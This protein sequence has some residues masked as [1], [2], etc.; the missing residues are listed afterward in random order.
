ML[1]SR[2]RGDGPRCVV[3]D[4]SRSRR[5]QPDHYEREHDDGHESQPTATVRPSLWPGHRNAH[6]LDESACLSRALKGKASIGTVDASRV[7]RSMS[8]GRCLD[9]LVASPR[10]DPFSSAPAVLKSQ[11]TEA[12]PHLPVSRPSRPGVRVSRG[13]DCDRRLRRGACH[14]RERG[15]HW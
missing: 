10:A 4:K 3:A 7:A 12:G 1:P 8:P 2:D 13:G 15:Q 14:R 9:N 11:L 6:C 5:A